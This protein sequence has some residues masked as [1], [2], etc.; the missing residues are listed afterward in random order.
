VTPL[1]R[2][3]GGDAAPL[4]QAALDRFAAALDGET[5]SI[6][7]EQ[8][9]AIDRRHRG[10]TAL[11]RITSGRTVLTPVSRRAP[12]FPLLRPATAATVSFV[13]DGGT[14]LAVEVDV[15]DG[16]LS[17]LSITPA[18]GD[19]APL[20]ADDAEVRIDVGSGLPPVEHEQE[21]RMSDVLERWARA[22]GVHDIS[23]PMATHDREW[24]ARALPFP[25]PPSY[26]DLCSLCDGVT[27]G[28]VRVYSLA[29]AA[30]TPFGGDDDFL[31]FAELVGEAVFLGILRSD[32][33]SEP[34][35]HAVEH[36]VPD[37]SI[38]LDRSLTAVVDRLVGGDP[39]LGARLG[40]RG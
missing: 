22:S 20:S 10:R 17:G 32:G 37:V 14:R 40:R 19:A 5:R 26:L 38:P 27:V 25:P 13:A 31:Y 21:P 39:E 11:V 34:V 1:F 16:Y 9:A 29:E 7:E 15:D 24:F 3:G 23:P 28:P 33:S 30:R 8:I 6:A 35:I 4:E 18:P 36:D 2:R 12:R